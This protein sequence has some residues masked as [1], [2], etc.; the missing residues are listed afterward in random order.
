MPHQCTK[1][2][3]KYANEQ[4]V[5][6]CNCGSTAFFFTRRDVEE[7]PLL[8]DGLPRLEHGEGKYEIDLQALLKRDVV[9]EDSEGKYTINLHEGFRRQR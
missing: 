1:C 4:I 7:T 8:I 6:M 2:N 5:M 3:T 9:T